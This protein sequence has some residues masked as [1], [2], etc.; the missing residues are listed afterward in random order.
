MTFRPLLVLFV[1]GVLTSHATVLPEIPPSERILSIE[2]VRNYWVNTLRG[3][4]VPPRPTGLHPDQQR[5]WSDMVR[6]RQHL[7]E[8]ARQGEFDDQAA[9]VALRHNANAWRMRGDEEQA[10]KIEA[11]LRALEI[12]RKQLEVLETQR[13]AALAQIEMAERVAALE[14]R[15]SSL[16]SDYQRLLARACD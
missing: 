5:Q 4:P 8:R 3:R 15:L 7:I 11:K 13:R 1:C 10:E 2:E 6:A 12:H 16:R 14:S 9:F